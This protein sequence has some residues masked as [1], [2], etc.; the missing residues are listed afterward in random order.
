[1][2]S[3]YVNQNRRTIDKAFRIMRKDVDTTC[4]NGM[5]DLLELGVRYCL[6][7]HD[8]QHQH[9]LDTGDSYGWSLV[10][11]GAEIKRKI[12]ANG[13]SAIGNAS[14]S[15]DE[16]IRHGSLPSGYVGVIL[17]GMHPVHYF[18]VRFEFYAMRRGMGELSA[19]DF[20]KYFKPVKI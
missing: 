2:P 14:S 9:H 20:N 7:S 13:G 12:Y 1:M 10:K 19:E 15:L 16:V 4:R 11:D 17:A 5:I 6:E 3:S 8:S 18:A